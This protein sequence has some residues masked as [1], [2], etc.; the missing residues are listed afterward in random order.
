MFDIKLFYKCL[1][2]C[3]TCHGRS[4][5]ELERKKGRCLQVGLSLSSARRRSY[6]KSAENVLSSFFLQEL[7][8]KLSFS[9]M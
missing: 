9:V 8:T 4:G 2:I 1:L 3:I 6:A 7:A 5:C